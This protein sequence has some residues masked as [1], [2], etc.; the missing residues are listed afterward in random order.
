MRIF[1]KDTGNFRVALMLN[2]SQW[3]ITGINEIK[4]TPKAA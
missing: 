1:I 3:I 2:V 4:N